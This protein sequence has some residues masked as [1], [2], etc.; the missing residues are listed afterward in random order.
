M[1]ETSAHDDPRL[2]RTR[3]LL[4]ASDVAFARV[5]AAGH[6]REILVVEGDPSSADELARLAPAIRALGFRYVTV[7]LGGIRS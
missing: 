6:T 7:D 3:A 4:A 1:S 2:E 5:R